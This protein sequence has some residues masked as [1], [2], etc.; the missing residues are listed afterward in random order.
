[1]LSWF[2]K[3]LDVGDLLVLL[4]FRFFQKIF[5]LVK[6]RSLMQRLPSARR[7]LCD[8]SPITVILRNFPLNLRFNH[9][10]IG[11]RYLDRSPCILGIE[12]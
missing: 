6:R 8:I 9:I 7:P 3:S 10:V 1:M 5:S 12:A 4:D 2:G 11:R